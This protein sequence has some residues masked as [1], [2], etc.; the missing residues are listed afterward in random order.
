MQ[1]DKPDQY[2]VVGNP[3][4][5]S[6][7]PFIHRQFAR[8][9][10]QFITYETLQAPLSGF[11]ERLLRFFAEGGKGCNVTVPFKEEAYALAD[12]LT[13]RAKLAGAVN[14]LKIMEDGKLLGDNTDGAGLVQDLRRQQVN[15]KDAHILVIGAGG[16]ARGV[17]LPLLEKNPATLT[18]ANRTLTKA[19][20]L[21]ALFSPY[22]KI[23]A[24][25]FDQ[26]EGVSFDL[27][28]NSTSASLSGEFPAIPAQVITAKTIVYDMVYGQ[29]VTTSNQW[30]LM[31]GARRVIDGL[32]MLVGQAAESFYLWRVCEPETEAVI[33]AL[34]KKLEHSE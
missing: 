12:R 17:L 27:I 2:V 26:L 14:T 29:G 25:A 33:E 31:H 16:A 21:A 6:Q 13:P 11:S 23:Q 9:T 15:L 34:R 3:I 30:A 22:G 1:Q 5:H 7:S 28:I 18:I 19:K 24:R 32:G 20:H 10:R 8:Q 4:S